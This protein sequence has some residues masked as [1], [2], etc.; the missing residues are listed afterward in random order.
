ML[1]L[2]ERILHLSEKPMITPDEFRAVQNAWWEVAPP[3][4]R[5]KFPGM[6][7]TEG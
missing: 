1:Q 4:L 6:N 5:L 7:G 3:A 2:P